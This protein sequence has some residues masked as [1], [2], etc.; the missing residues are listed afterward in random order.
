[1]GTLY[2]AQIKGDVARM[3]TLI[4][5]ATARCP[6]GAGLA[7]EKGTGRNG[8]WDC[9]DIL[10]KKALPLGHEG[11]KEHTAV[12]P[13]VFYEIKSELQPSAH[14]ATTRPLEV[15]MSPGRD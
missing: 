7:Y 5:A 6:C 14:G 13:F 12:L 9:A 15:I 2:A 11:Y 4:Y 3:I 10:L 1:V 8:A